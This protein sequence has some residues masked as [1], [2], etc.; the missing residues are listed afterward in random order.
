MIICWNQT[1]LY[2]VSKD[3]VHEGIMFKECQVFGGM[4]L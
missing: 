1:Q 4:K 2:L 3:I